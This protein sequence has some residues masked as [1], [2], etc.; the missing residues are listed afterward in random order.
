M[1][2]ERT[3]R[4]IQ[5]ERERHNSH[6]EACSSSVP[7]GTG[8]LSRQKM[9]PEMRF[10]TMT[11]PS[12]DAVANMLGAFSAKHRMSS[13]CPFPCKKASVLAQQHCVSFGFEIWEFQ[14]NARCPFCARCPAEFKASVLAQQHCVSFGFGFWKFSQMQDVLFVSVALQKRLQLLHNC[15]VWA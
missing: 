12:Y 3:D 8:A 4:K 14:A 2:R 1:Y 7:S 9:C 15:T 6:M 13:L 10:H 11:S 5:R